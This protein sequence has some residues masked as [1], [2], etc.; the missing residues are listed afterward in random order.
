VAIT[1][2]PKHLVLILAREFATRLATPMFITDAQGT[3]VFYNEPAEE[4]LGRTFADAGE[5]AAE[6]WGSLFQVEGLDGRPMAL[7]DMPGGIALGERRAAHDTIRITGLDGVQ[8]AISITAFPLF[9]RADEF[10]GIVTVFWEAEEAR[11]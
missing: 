3:L 2:R 5:I 9:A 10:V 11:R 6:D 4:L 7:E 1:R 8:R